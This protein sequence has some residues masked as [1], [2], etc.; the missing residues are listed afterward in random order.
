MINLKI[1]ELAQGEHKMCYIGIYPALIR[2]VFIESRIIAIRCLSLRYITVI[3]ILG[4]F[5]A[6]VMLGG[7]TGTTPSPAASVTPT[8][9]IGHSL[10]NPAPQGQP[11][12]GT[13]KQKLEDGSTLS[14]NMTLEQVP[15]S[16]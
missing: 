8:P 14:L 13:A 3:V 11:V 2:F 7:C 1:V 15:C 16:N 5:I 10:S 9:E 12:T 6:T 4:I